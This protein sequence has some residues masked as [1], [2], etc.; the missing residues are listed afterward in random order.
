MLKR[1]LIISGLGFGVFLLGVGVVHF[2]GFAGPSFMTGHGWFA[3]PTA[4][5]LCVLLSSG[6]FALAFFSARTGRDEISD[7]SEDSSSVNR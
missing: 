3:F 4:S 5:F 6:L 2:S 7:L 1:I